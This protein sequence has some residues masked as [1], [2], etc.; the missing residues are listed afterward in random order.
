MRILIIHTFGLGD[1]IM[2]TP[3]LQE[4]IQRYPDAKIDFLIFQK[5]ASYPILHSP[6]VNKIYHTSFKIREIVKSIVI[7]RKQKYDMSFVTSGTNPL[8]AGLFS[9]L[10]AAQERI[11]EYRKLKSPF[12][13][14]NILYQE[15]QHR[16]E[17]NLDLIGASHTSFQP[18]YYLENLHK[19]ANSKTVRIGF[20]IGSNRAFA[21]KRWSAES[22]Y[23]LVM[24]LKKHYSNLEILIFSGPDE[25]E[26]SR[27]LAEQSSSKLCL[28]LP[29][30]TM[31]LEIASCDMFI[32]TDSGLGHIASCF[33]VEIFT[34]FGPA[35]DYKA[36]PYT[37]KG[38]IVKLNLPCQP[39]YG[40]SDFNR[41]KHLKCLNELTPEMVF[42]Q[43]TK[44]SKVLVHAK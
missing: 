35:K 4:L 12:F 1:M 7:L 18:I 42:E 26:E 20:H 44:E 11:G 38:H 3:A 30:D 37:K 13:T 36:R 24:L 6:R 14:K 43:I 28:N 29:F 10:V 17:N 19:R 27:K 8:K 25:E 34:I 33:D 21:K 2:F 23:I 5:F 39:C 16:V 41:C 32:N 9:F 15:N 40:T 22:F 31:A